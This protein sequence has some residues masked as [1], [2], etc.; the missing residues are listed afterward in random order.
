MQQDTT[1]AFTHFEEPP[2]VV[3]QR[4]EQSLHEFRLKTQR[5][6]KEIEDYL[7]VAETLGSQGD[8]HGEKEKLV[9]ELLET[10]QQLQ[11]TST[12][13]EVLTSMTVTFFRNLHQV[14]F[15]F[16]HTIRYLDTNSN[17]LFRSMSGLKE[18][19]KNSKS[20][21]YLRTTPRKW[22]NWY[23][24]IE[25]R[26]KPLKNLYG[27]RKQRVNKLFEDQDNQ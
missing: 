23:K 1:L 21:G 4:L 17:L 27:L 25:R 26:V 11:Q 18:L 2:A 5:T 16:V 7:Q 9:N 12:Q 6:K 13:F 8:T 24:N 14:H 19:K 22:S 20:K 3:A 15:F 10:H